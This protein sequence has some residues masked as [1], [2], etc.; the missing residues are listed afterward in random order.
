MHRYLRFVAIPP[1]EGLL[2]KGGQDVVLVQIA[3]LLPQVLEHVTGRHRMHLQLMMS[4][5]ML[6]HHIIY[7]PSRTSY[8]HHIGII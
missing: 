5:T 1:G 8:R 6:Y 4:V 2:E 3:L 7:A